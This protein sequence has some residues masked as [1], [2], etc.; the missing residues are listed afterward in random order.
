[1]RPSSI[2]YEDNREIVV[3]GRKVR[4]PTRATFA[5]A[6]GDDSLRVELSIEDAIGTDTRYESAIAT[7]FVGQKDSEKLGAMQ[8][9]GNVQTPYFI[10]MKGTARVSGRVGGSPIAGSGSGFFETYR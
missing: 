1:F 5:D 4:V 8:G 3:N 6:R 10:Q 7:P 9:A 2:S